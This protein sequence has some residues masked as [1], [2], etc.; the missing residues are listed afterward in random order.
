MSEELLQSPGQVI[1]NEIIL[2]SGKGVTLGITDYCY[3]I[4]IIIR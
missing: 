3:L 1:I 2:I 4:Y